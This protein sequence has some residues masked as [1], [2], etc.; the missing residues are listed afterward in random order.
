MA[1]A[2]V[3]QMVSAVL[4]RGPGHLREVRL[5]TQEWMSR[6]GYQSVRSLRGAMDLEACP[7]PAAYERATAILALQR[8][9]S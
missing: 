5:A 1:G 4:A 7:D 3:V 6:H 8:W 9:P 2:R